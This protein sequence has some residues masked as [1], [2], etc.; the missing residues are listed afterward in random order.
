MHCGHCRIQLSYFTYTLRELLIIHKNIVSNSA[1]SFSSLWLNITCSQCEPISSSLHFSNWHWFRW[2]SSVFQSS[3]FLSHQYPEEFTGGQFGHIKL[4][5]TCRNKESCAPVGIV[6]ATSLPHTQ[7]SFSWKQLLP[8]FFTVQS[9]Q[10]QL[11]FSLQSQTN[12]HSVTTLS[13]ST[14]ST[15]FCNLFLFVTG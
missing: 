8:W 6:F 15:R 11:C 2:H 12:L 10:S 1:I 9:L 4:L 3:C 13:Y 14:L 5:G 7:M